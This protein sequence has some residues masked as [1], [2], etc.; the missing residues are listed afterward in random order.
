MCHAFASANIPWNTVENPSFKSFLEK[1]CS[2]H[3]PS[4]STLRKSYLDPVY[5]SA[6]KEIREDINNCNIWISVDET[7]DSVGRYIVNLI[8]GKMDENVSGKA[9]LLCSKEVQKANAKSIAY[10]INSEL[11]TLYPNGVEDQRVLL[12]LTDAAAYMIAAG[13]LLKPFYPNLTHL[14][15]LVHGLH[16]VAEEVRKL[17]PTVNTL[18]SSVKKVFLKAPSRISVFREKLP[19]TPLPPEPVITRWGTWLKA[20][21]YYAKN[22]EQMKVI[23]NE[24]DEED[25]LSI[26]AA[27]CVFKEKGI[28]EDLAYID[29]H[30]TFVVDTIQQLE[31]SSLSLCQSM[32]L[33]L[34]AKK[35]LEEAPGKHASKICEKLKNVLSRNPGYETIS[36]VYNVLSGNGGTVPKEFNVDMVAQF[37]YAP[38][39]SVHVERSFSAY[40]LILSN[41][42]DRSLCVNLEKLLVIYCNSN[43][44]F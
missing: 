13:Q 5:E 20:V 8:V 10:F 19:D 18:I 33:F 7:T 34:S 14:T 23:V 15:C 31:A 21:K 40:K 29:A 37:K 24:F 43:Y 41:K 11:K 26:K 4:E 1:Y 35:R 16:R 28:K 2:R 32:S 30:F 44:G 42:R 9:H 12:L 38:V 25:S 22:F 3:I 6:I 27:Q 36:S 39:T 17:F